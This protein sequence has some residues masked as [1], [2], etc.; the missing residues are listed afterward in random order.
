MSYTLT[1]LKKSSKLTFGFVFCEAFKIEGLYVSLSSISSV[2][3]RA[4]QS[5]LEVFLKQ[6]LGVLFSDVDFHPVSLAFFSSHRLL[7]IE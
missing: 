3:Y 5:F 4:S 6:Y 2:Q 1:K 7:C